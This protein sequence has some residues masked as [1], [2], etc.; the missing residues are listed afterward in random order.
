[1]SDETNSVQLDE[2]RRMSSHQFDEV[3]PLRSGESEIEPR[4]ASFALIKAQI[5][6]KLR[7]AA[8]TLRGKAEGNQMPREGANFGS[9]AG[10]WLHNSANE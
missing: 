4:K 1:M 2:E 3:A 10:A 6:D 9:H 8:E 7:Q 5:A